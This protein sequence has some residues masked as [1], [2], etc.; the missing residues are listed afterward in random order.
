L[1]SMRVTPALRHQF[2]CAQNMNDFDA[3]IRT[4]AVKGPTSGSRSGILPEMHI[5]VPGG[6]VE[7]W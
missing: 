3:A 5:P 6:P 2:Q 7:R 1:K 4:I